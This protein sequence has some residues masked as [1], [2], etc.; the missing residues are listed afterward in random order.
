MTGRCGMKDK[1]GS[2][3]ALVTVT[4]L[5][6]GFAYLCI[7]ILGRVMTAVFTLLGVA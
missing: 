5:G 3:L 7:Q 6:T 2:A 4:V 1:I